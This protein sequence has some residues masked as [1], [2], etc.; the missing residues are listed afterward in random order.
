MAS[1][2]TTMRSVIRT[3]G[4]LLVASLALAVAHAAPPAELAQWFGPQPWQRD[5]DGPIV[6]LGNPG[7]FDDQHIF[8]PAVAEEDG[9]FLLWYSGSRGTPGNRVFRLGLATGTD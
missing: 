9:R 8:A 4:L 5:S 6:S 7:E 1:E 2:N 3:S